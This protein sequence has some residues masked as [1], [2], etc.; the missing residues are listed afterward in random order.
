MMANTLGR[1]PPEASGKRVR[2]KLRDGTV[3]G[4][5]PVNTDSKLGWAADTTN[6]ALAGHRADVIEWE[7][8]A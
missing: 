1:C 5:M 3:H 7:L 8:T 4:F 2:V 6:W